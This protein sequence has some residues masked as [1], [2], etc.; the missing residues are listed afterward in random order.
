MYRCLLSEKTLD[1]LAFS[2]SVFCS[3]LK[4]RGVAILSFV[5]LF[6]VYGSV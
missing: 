1:I 4:G 5:R 2:I 6:L 3:L